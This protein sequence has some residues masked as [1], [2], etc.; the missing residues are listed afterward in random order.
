MREEVLSRIHYEPFQNVFIY[1]TEKCN[2]HCAHCYLGKR[3]E[4]GH[5]MSFQNFKRVLKY[6]SLFGNPRITLLGGEPT[7]HKDLPLMV[8]ES[9]R[10]GFQTI[11]DTNG[12]FPPPLLTKLNNEHLLYLSFSLDSPN[13]KVNDA[14]RGKGTFEKTVSNIRYAIRLGF[15]VRVLPTVSMLNISDA[16]DIVAFAETL[17]VSC[18]N[19]HIFSAIGRGSSH[20]EW[21]PSPAIWKDFCKILREKARSHKIVVWY[22]PTY[23]SKEELIDFVGKGYRGC[24][25]RYFDRC[26]V[27]PDG[28]I[29]LCACFFDTPY[30]FATYTGKTILLNQRANEI[31]FQLRIQEPCWDCSYFS[32]CKGGCAAERILKTS[33]KCEDHVSL[34]RLWKI[35]ADE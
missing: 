8:K 31:N 29:Y 27:F 21:A 5:A 26:D 35:R 23:C 11:L 13:K 28:T 3:L 16:S 9:Y 32:A 25:T 2:L 12:T 30:N 20:S 15:N 14:I 33:W 17:G 1:V 6:F 4:Q 10:M 7:M 24:V 19:F 34:C 22:P 18:V